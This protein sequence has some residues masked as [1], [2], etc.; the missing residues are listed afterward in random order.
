MT[1]LELQ[2][3]LLQNH[4]QENE[5]CEWKEFKSLKHSIAA[6]EGDD[7]ISYVSAIA[8]MEGGYLI[9][10][11]EDSTLKIVGIQ[12]F[13]TY[14]TTNLKLK[15]LNDCTNLSSERFEITEFKT[16]DTNKIIWIFTI[17]KHTYRLPVYAHKKC[18]QRINDSLVI[19]SQSRLDAIL[20]ET[21]VLDD[22][23]AQII[24][25]A[26]IEDLD[27][28]AIKKARIEFVKR[29]PS[30][31]EE[32]KTWNDS[33]FLDKAK[34]TIKGKITRTALILLGD[35]EAEH[36]LGSAVKIRWILR[37]LND[38]NKGSQIF[39]IPFILNVDQVFAKIRNLNYIYTKD[40]TLFP[41]EMPRYDVFTIREP[42]HN[43]IAHQDY[44]MKGYINVIEYEDD[45]LVFSNLGHFLPNT[46]QDVVL[47]DTPQENYRN[48]FLVAAMK[49]LNMIETEGGGIRKIFNFQRQRLFPM[50]DY[51][52][53]DNKCKLNI[54]GKIIN[55]DFGRILIKNP[56]LKLAD[57]ILLDKVQKKSKELTDEQISYLKKKQFIEGRKS[58]VFLS[59]KVIEPIN[60]EILNAEYIDNKSFNDAYFKDL[61]I[62]YLRKFPHSKRSAIDALI[63]PKLSATLTDVQ[64]KKKIEN[65]LTSLRIA[66]KIKTNENKEW[67]LGQI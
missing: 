54:L 29:N 40:D 16:S 35:E 6:K 4:P 10:G 1:E 60:D 65:F 56:S 64:K 66:K 59:I 18:W 39:S 13:H 3:Y 42:L 44:T 58:N 41:E 24:E 48:P 32:E 43:A 5:K 36:Y 15:I 31:L 61:I 11:V 25:D 67:S 53:S 14:N 38:Q 28:D 45:H 46:V 22:W 7:V 51:D 47:Q 20:A 37:N 63:L 50:P 30:K 34:L 62:E 57:I 23:T 21:K 2:N 12:D 8:N 27:K 17:P 49:N 52:I 26:T 33:K 55:L 9:I 19:I